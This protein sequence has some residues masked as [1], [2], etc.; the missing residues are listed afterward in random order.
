MTT[1]ETRILNFRVFNVSMGYLSGPDI[2]PPRA[3]LPEAANLEI[4][5]NWYG[6]E[7]NDG[8]LYRWVN[9]DAELLVRMPQK[10]KSLVLVLELESGPGLDQK[11]FVIQ[12]RNA[13]G[14][15]IAQANAKESGFVN[16][17]L[18]FMP[19]QAE[20]IKLHVDGGGR[21]ISNERRILNF[22]VFKA[23]LSKPV[24]V[25]ARRNLLKTGMYEDG[26]VTSRSVFQIPQLKNP[27]TL[28]VRGVIPMLADKKYSTEVRL[29]V[30]DQEIAKKTLLPG[31][32]ELQATPPVGAGNRRVSLLF[33]K[34]QVLPGEDQRLVAGLLRYVGFDAPA[35]P[36]AMSEPGK[37]IPL[38]T[39][40]ITLGGGWYP[41]EAQQ[42]ALFRWV[43]NNAELRLTPPTNGR[44]ALSLTV[45]P[46]PGVGSQPFE[47]R[48]LDTEKKLLG[49]VT[50][51]G[52]ETIRVTL[53]VIT[54]KASALYFLQVKE[55]GKA[56]PNDLRIL[57]FRVFKIEWSKP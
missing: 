48:L 5:E 2:V 50:V 35:K 47:L 17:A 32:F 10:S 28:T 36:D 54:E 22:R 21:Q 19:G 44:W 53:P 1:G 18:P 43:N 52:K 14:A 30:N 7:N 12:A 39:D 42:D 41:V 56:T 57:N 20:A 49:T 34:S 51:R 11:P 27:S 24:D 8:Q 3:V 6:T 37:E 23:R 46:G 55:G 38:P 4:G 33:S 45:E 26:W 40:G 13:A 25:F 29:L 31:D 16:L 15:V 9:N